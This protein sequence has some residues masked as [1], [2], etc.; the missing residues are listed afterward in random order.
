MSLMFPACYTWCAAQARSPGHVECTLPTSH[1]S[2]PS[3]LA[4][5]T[6]GVG[7]LPSG[8]GRLTIRTKPEP[9][10]I[11]DVMDR[12]D[13]GA[14]LTTPGQA[15]EALGREQDYRGQDL[16]LPQQGPGSV[17]L[18]S[19]RV[20]AIVIDWAAALL[21]ASL[22]TPYLMQGNADFGL[23]TLAVFAFEI[24]VL[25]WLSGSSFGQR[26]TKVSIVRVDNGRL[27]LIPVV[28]RTSL[29]CLV[30]PALIWDRDTRGLHDKAAGTVCVER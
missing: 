18:V 19:R 24:V 1:P 4:G 27:G 25:T 30:I 20:I 28:V 15:P 2:S 10:A 11:L 29:L 26:I 23:V 6:L 9:S 12:R 21:I 13:I 8:P 16:G 3:E 5:S 7:W 17:A 14:W 22:I